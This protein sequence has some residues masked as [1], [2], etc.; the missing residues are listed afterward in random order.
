[1][2]VEATLQVSYREEAG[3]YPDGMPYSLR[4][5]RYQLINPQYGPLSDHLLMSPRI[6]NQIIG[7]G[8]IEV[9]SCSGY[10]DEVRPD[11]DD[12]DG[13]SGRVN[14]VW[15]VDRQDY[16]IGRFGWKASQPSVRQQVAAAF[17]GDLGITSDL[18]PDENHT[19]LQVA[20]HHKP[21]G[22]DQF[23]QEL[24]Q[25]VLDR[26]TFFCQTIGIP[27]RQEPT[28]PTVLRGQHIFHRINCASCHTPAAH[29]DRCSLWSS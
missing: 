2:P 9:Y 20:A 1:M 13:I 7:L 25:I 6:G 16:V 8:F 29:A 28:H 18:F 26:V 5:P 14:E 12:N 21:N 17:Q 27:A 19:D 22:Q 10:L 15:S 11:D 3:T 4:H 23:G 24:Q